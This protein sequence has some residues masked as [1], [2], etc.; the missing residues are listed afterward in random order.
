MPCENIVPASVEL[1]QSLPSRPE[2][3]SPF[4]DQLLDFARRFTTNDLL[5]DDI[6]T[7]VREALANAMIHGNR[8]RPEKRVLVACR[9]SAD[10]EVSITV[11]D[12]GE[13]FEIGAVRDPTDARALLLNHGR[14][15]YL[16]KTLMDHVSFEEAGTV[17][18]M[19]KRILQA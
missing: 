17:V 18:R 8:E 5:I 19:R 11:R 1:Q 6:E 7:A 16:M 15:I 4:V 2:V 14:G 12:E 10:G 3:I 9:Y 13:G